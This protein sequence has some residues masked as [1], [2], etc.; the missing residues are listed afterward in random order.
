MTAT[1]YG[2]HRNGRATRASLLLLLPVLT[3]FARLGHILS[4][5]VIR[6]LYRFHRSLNHGRALLGIRVFCKYW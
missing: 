3:T 5:Q 2:K 1:I 4:D 6:M